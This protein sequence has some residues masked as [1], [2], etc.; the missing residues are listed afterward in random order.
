MNKYPNSGRLN[1]SKNKIHPK[2]PD[3]YGEMSFDRSFLRT[4]L[5]D[6]EGDDIVIKLDAWQ[7]DG[8]YGPWFSIKVNTYKKPEE[9]SPVQKQAA[10]VLDEGDLPF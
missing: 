2:S 9:A 3:M 6:I 10:P 7:Q 5:N 4:L 8:N 1:Y